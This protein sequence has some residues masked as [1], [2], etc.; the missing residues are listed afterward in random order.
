MNCKHRL[1]SIK[2]LLA[3]GPFKF[4]CMDCGCTVYRKHPKALIP[5]QALFIDRIGILFLIS[6][7]ALFSYL[8]IA[9]TVFL[10]ITSALYVFDTY[11]EPLKECAENDRAE[12]RNKNRKIYIFLV[13]VALFGIG[14]YILEKLV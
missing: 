3:S 13:I 7:V 8:P 10:S 14:T 1:S 12:D 6:V 5:W 9:L 4:E 11:N 2:A